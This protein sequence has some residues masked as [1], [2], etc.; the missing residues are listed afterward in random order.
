MSGSVATEPARER[1]ARL[2]KIIAQ[3]T[4]QGHQ[5]RLVIGGLAG[6]VMNFTRGLEALAPRAAT[7]VRD[8]QA[9][10]A[11]YGRLAPAERASQL[12]ALGS[13]LDA[14]D[15]LL[16]DVG[17]EPAGS[18]ATPAPISSTIATAPAAQVP[19]RPASVARPLDPS[20]PVTAL[21]MVGEG[22]ARLLARLGIGSV[23]D[24]LYHL[25]LR[26]DDF[27]RTPPIAGLMYGQPQTVVGRFTTVE[28]S[29][30]RGNRVR[31]VARLVDNTGSIR[32]TWFW[33]AQMA[34]GK[35]L[36]LDTPVVVSGRVG[37]FNG[38][39]A[40]EQPD[41]EDAD[42]D[43]LHVGR[44]VPIYGATE[45]LYQKQLRAMA[46][47]ALAVTAATLVDPL[48]EPLRLDAGLSPL[49]P[50]LAQAHFPATEADRQAGRQRLAF[51][52]LL[53]VQLGMQQRRR[54]WQATV[55]PA[56]PSDGEA[57]A[58]VAAFLT[59][60]PFA[61]T[62]AQRRSLNDVRRDLA[63]PRPMSRLIQGDV[64]SGKTVVAAAAMLLATAHGYQAALMAPTELLAEQHAL[65]LGTLFERLPEGQWPR[66]ALLKG[67]LPARQKR[68]VQASI[69]AGKVDII[70][71]THAVIQ[72]SIAFD[73][74][75]L[76]VVDEQ[77]RFGVAQRAGLRSKGDNP[78]LLVMTATPIP[79]SLALTMHGDLDVSII[80]ELPP[81]RQTIATQLVSPGARQDAY[82]LVRQEVKAG[83][84]AYIVCP[85]VEESEVIEA[86]AATAE[87]ERL[88]QEVFPDLR[89][90][91]VHGRLRPSE[92]D[93]VMR[94]FRDGDLDVLVSTAV[95]E[96]GIDVPNAT[97][98]VIEGAD[99]FGLAQ[100]HQ[101]RG[102]VGRGAHASTCLLL[103]D[104]ASDRATER[105][106]ALVE[107]SDG[108]EVAEFDLRLR[109][110]GE[111]FGTRQSGLPPL[112]L[113]GLGDVRAIELA[114]R[115]AIRILDEDPS[116][117]LPVYQPLAALLA[118]FWAD[119]AGDVS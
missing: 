81:G 31:V 38:V 113:A 21:P 73:R 44:L 22:R 46:R 65:T 9:L 1:L 78:H 60:L 33:P 93:A 106:R 80:D 40:F 35:R 79:R 82:D 68:E 47:A 29:P 119:G 24:L 70:A 111:F 26:H 62:G 13:R 87:H 17:S 4:I 43:L 96:V 69:A 118:S 58:R 77:H 3:E 99:R 61:L 100:L 102:R 56:L 57:W 110:P 63:A 12:T 2:R 72:A 112:Q 88:Q 84:Q 39:L 34:R 41:Y 25:P 91:L 75:A 86:R 115:T 74:L 107:T 109:G 36:P 27:T 95:I 49:H 48:P 114:Q 16:R 89:I 14:L 105:L 7:I 6:L 20:A 51:D 5:D 76:A 98:M 23:R 11:D 117:A 32:C 54:A 42:A 101:F 50:A 67:S 52:E 8:A 45:G 37:Q 108:F 64:G 30:V 85:L 66:L 59:S 104:D 19:P 116:L 71:G 15:A 103:T 97:V 28:S 94:A 10:V 18:P 55:A 83:R 92:K 53:L 90:G